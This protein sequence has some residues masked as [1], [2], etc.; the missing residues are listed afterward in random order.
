[1]ASSVTN[2]GADFWLPMPTGNTSVKDRRYAQASPPVFSI[3][4]LLTGKSWPLKSDSF[5][6]GKYESQS[7]ISNAQLL[8]AGKRK[9]PI[10]YVLFGLSAVVGIWALAVMSRKG[11]K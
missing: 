7:G 3:A 6:L 5:L 9:R 11:A 8:A 4:Y 1:M 2:L 10:I